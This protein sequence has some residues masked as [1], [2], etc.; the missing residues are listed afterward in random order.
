MSG[1]RSPYTTFPPPNLACI[2]HLQKLLEEKCHLIAAKNLTS[3]NLALIFAVFFLQTSDLFCFK[4]MVLFNF[5]IRSKFLFVS[6][7]VFTA[8]PISFSTKSF[9]K[10]FRLKFVSWQCSFLSHR[11]SAELHLFFPCNPLS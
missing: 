11:S 7:C 9:D 3:A 6:Y 5:I 1:Q 2:S 10:P 8:F 4:I